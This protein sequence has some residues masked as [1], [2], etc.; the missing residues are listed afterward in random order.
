MALEKTL[1]IL[2]IISAIAFVI[3]VF[4]PLW[5]NANNPRLTQMELLLNF[6]WLYSIGIVL[7]MVYLKWKE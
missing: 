2:R 3:C 7:G 6:W 4:Y 1:K 5:Y